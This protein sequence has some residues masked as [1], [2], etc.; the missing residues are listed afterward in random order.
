[1]PLFDDDDVVL[2]S[3]RRG[4]AV[5]EQIHSVTRTKCFQNPDL[6]GVL[7]ADQF[8]MLLVKEPTDVE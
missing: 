1:M 4:N 3:M 6:L 2:V 8:Q 7:L 5:I